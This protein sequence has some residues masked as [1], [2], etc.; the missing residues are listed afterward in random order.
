MEAATKSGS[1]TDER[2][3]EVREMLATTLTVK[4]IECREQDEAA[5]RLK[6]RALPAEGSRLLC[7]DRQG[8]GR[9]ER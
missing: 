6:S 8:S 7:E 5:G 1:Y 9:R 4:V 3:T 2:W